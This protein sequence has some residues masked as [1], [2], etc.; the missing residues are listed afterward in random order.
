MK[1]TPD[2]ILVRPAEAAELLGVSRSKIYELIASG[3]VP[4]LRLEGGRMLRIPL[5][6]LRRLGQCGIKRKSD[7]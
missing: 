5:A 4:S 7:G 3:A 1:K 6:E 2:P